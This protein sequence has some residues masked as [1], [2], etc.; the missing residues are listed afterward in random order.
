M[1]WLGFMFC[2]KTQMLFWQCFDEIEDKIVIDC[3]LCAGFYGQVMIGDT[4][5]IGDMKLEFMKDLARQNGGT[6][7]FVKD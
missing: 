1:V 2:N 6:Y 3:D 4:I 5:A 7:I